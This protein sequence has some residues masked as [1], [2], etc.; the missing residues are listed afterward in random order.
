M[1]QMG[2]MPRVSFSRPNISA[3]FGMRRRTTGAT[4]VSPVDTHDWDNGRLTRCGTTGTTGVSPVAG[5]DWD[6]GRLARSYTGTMG[7]PPV[8]GADWDNGRLA[9]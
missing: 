8:A 5:A 9:R 1:G 7:V 4:G 6:N 2:P 3:P